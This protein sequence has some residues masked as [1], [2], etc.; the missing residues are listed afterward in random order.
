MER[1][2]QPSLFPHSHG[3][4]CYAKT[5][6]GRPLAYTP[7]RVDGAD[8]NLRNLN[9]ADFRPGAKGLTLVCTLPTLG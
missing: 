8:R 7:C 1:D 5:P 6:D 9:Q 3:I 4:D 2:K